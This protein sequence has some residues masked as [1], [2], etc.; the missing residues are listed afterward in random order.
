[1]VLNWNWRQQTPFPKNEEQFCV[2]K[3]MLL[4]VMLCYESWLGFFVW[5]WRTREGITNEGKGM[6]FCKVEN[7]INLTCKLGSFEE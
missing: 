5:F 4:V 7:S 2:K 6:E 3:N 1:M